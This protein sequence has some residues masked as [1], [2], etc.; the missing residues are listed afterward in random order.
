MNG[1]YMYFCSSTVLYTTHM[2]IIHND[3]NGPPLHMVKYKCQW[4]T[5]TCI[6]HEHVQYMYMYM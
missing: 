1:I 3:S 2:I 6:V 5:S 4:P